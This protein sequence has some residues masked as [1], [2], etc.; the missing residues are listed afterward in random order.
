MKSLSTFA[1][2]A[3]SRSLFVWSAFLLFA[4]LLAALTLRHAMWLDEIEAW[5]VVRDSPSI[6]ALFH[7][8]HSE[9]HPSLWYLLL[10]PLTRITS[11]PVAMQALNYLIA[12]LLAWTVLTSPRL[13]PALAS[14]IVFSSILFNEYSLVARN[15]ALATL[16]I[17]LAVR[18]LLASKPRP[19][20]AFVLLGLAV[21]T[22]FL[23]IPVVLTIAAWFVLTKLLSRSLS[24]PRSLDI[25]RL[26]TCASVLL[27]SL[28]LCYLTVRPAPDLAPIDLHQPSTLG[29]FLI[30]EGR[31]WRIFFHLPIGHLSPHLI[32]LLDPSRVPSILASLLSLATLLLATSA[33]RSRSARLLFLAAAVFE[34]VILAAIMLLPEVRHYGFIFVAFVAAVLVDAAHPRPRRAAPL[35]LCILLLILGQQCLLTLSISAQEWKHPFS[36]SRQTAL[37]IRQNGLAANPVVLMPI[38]GSNAVLGYLEKPRAWF[39]ACQCWASFPLRNVHV[40]PQR[41]L[42][43]SDLRAAHASSPLPVLVITNSPLAPATQHALALSLLYSSGTDAIK[44]NENYLVYR[45]SDSQPGSM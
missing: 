9:G 18:V 17:L 4:A 16:F 2:S 32:D 21:N 28:L 10:Y 20:L 15:Y 1:P 8:L 33:F 5:L 34:I 6:A 26:L 39:P 12:L 41:P 36:A 27:V 24:S 44:Q 40:Q 37:W 11:N 30:L 29:H 45:Q 19:I 31:L 22:H 13:H 7:N 3:P 42:A 23:A 38:D 43:L 25:P 35:A 14:L